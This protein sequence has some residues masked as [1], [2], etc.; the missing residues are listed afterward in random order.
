MISIVRT[1]HQRVDNQS[2]MAKAQVLI[3]QP[4]KDYN[5]TRLYST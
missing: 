1:L 4:T 5:Q 3:E 2:D